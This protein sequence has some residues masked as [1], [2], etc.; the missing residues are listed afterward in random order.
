MY[1]LYG[2]LGSPY[3]MKLRA[4]LRYRRLPHAWV[5]GPEA[6]AIAGS[7]V[8]APVIPVLEYPDGSFHN[9]STPVIL[10]LESRHTHRGVVPP[11]PA[12]AFIAA[13]IEDF[14]DEWLTKAMFGYRWLRNVDQV[15][16]SRWLAYDQMKGGGIERSQAAAEAFRARQVGRMAIVG[17]TEANFPL[18]EASTRAVMAALEAHVTD[19][20]CL[21]GSRPSL[22]EFGLYGQ[23]SQLGVD[24][25]PEAMLRADYPYAFRWLLHIDDMSGIDGDWDAPG[26][27]MAPVVTALLAIIGALY[28]P[29]LDANAAALAA[30]AETFTI[31]AMGH[32][33]TQGTFKYQAKCL[34]EL[35]RHYAVLPGEARARL[36]PLLA[37]TGCLQALTS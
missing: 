22:A 11:D 25:T 19:R 4:V 32:G 2:A 15:Q 21:F 12:T 31:T 23:I 33:Y 30:G 5:H 3:S 28:F 8:K 1:T 18:I 35:R 37:E 16:M 27:P 24:P 29:F 17:C 26:T 20:H 34:A 7:K 36:E 14:A 9:D 10:D 13:L 6:M